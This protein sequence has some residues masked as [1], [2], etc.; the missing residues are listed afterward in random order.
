MRRA[1]GYAV[2]RATVPLG[3][4]DERTYAVDSSLWPRGVPR[5]LML[6]CG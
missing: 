5:A 3:P 6:H 2:G 1:V 4:T